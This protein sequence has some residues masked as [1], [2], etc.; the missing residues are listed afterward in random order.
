MWEGGSEP[1]EAQ[2]HWPPHPYAI[3]F[4]G[5]HWVIL[6]KAEGRQ[7]THG[8]PCWDTGVQSQLGLQVL[9]EP[10]ETV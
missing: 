7:C 5:P 8:S 1:L 2:A 6:R 9:W 3:Q 10:E 4:K